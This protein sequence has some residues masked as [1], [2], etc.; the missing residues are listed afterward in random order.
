MYEKV[1][2]YIWVVLCSA[3]YLLCSPEPVCLSLSQIPHVH[4]D[5]YVPAC[6]MLQPTICTYVEARNGLSS[7][8]RG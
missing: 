8:G 2:V 7:Q 5:I 3:K 6:L 4:E 1:I